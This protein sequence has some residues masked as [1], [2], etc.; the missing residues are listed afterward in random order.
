VEAA[1]VPLEAVKLTAN[2]K[3]SGPIPKGLFPMYGGFLSHLLDH[4]S[5]GGFGR[6]KVEKHHAARTRYLSLPS[7]YI[8]MACPMVCSTYKRFRGFKRMGHGGG[9]EHAPQM[10]NG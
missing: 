8:Y 6:L 4:A 2:F 7:H 5:G 3:L 10:P 1:G 9:E